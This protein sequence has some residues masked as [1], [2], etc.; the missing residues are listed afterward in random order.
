MEEDNK[1]E[2]WT[3]HSMEFL[4]LSSADS[5]LVIKSNNLNTIK[6]YTPT[7]NFWD[8]NKREV[9]KLFV[10]KGVLKFEGRMDASARIFFEHIVKLWK[11]N[12]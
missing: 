4:D 11:E 8:E 6:F 7:F 5:S 2:P 12:I 3:S 10:E 1:K 9:G